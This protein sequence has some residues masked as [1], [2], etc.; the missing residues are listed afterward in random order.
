MLIVIYSMRSKQRFL[1]QLLLTENTSATLK[2]LHITAQKNSKKPPWTTSY[3]RQRQSKMTTLLHHKC[4]NRL[5]LHNLSN[6][7]GSI[8][9]FRCVTF[10]T[11]IY[12]LL[13]MLVSE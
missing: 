11:I 4:L 2:S 12:E 8:F 13:Y 7:V 6:P 3:G 1:K 9:C 10:G 5:T